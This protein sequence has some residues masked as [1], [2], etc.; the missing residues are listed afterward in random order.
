[1]CHPQHFAEWVTSMHAFGSVDPVMLA[2][3]EL[4][5]AEQG[6]A[7]GDACHDCHSPSLKRQRDWLASL[8]PEADPVLEDVSLDGISCDVCHSIDLIP[9]AGDISFL[10]DVDPSGPKLGGIADPVANDFHESKL[11]HSFRTSVQC[12]SCHQIHLEN[13]TGVEN[14]FQEWSDSIFSGMGRE[15]QDCHMPAYTGPAATGGPPDRTVHHHTFVGVDFATVPYRGIDRDRQI[16]AV[17][18]LLRNSVTVMPELPLVTDPGAS[19]TLRFPVI[20]DRTGHSI[21]S[22]TTFSREMWI[23]LTVRDA[24]DS[25]VYR[26]GWLEGADSTLVGEDVDPDL[27]SFGG[28]LLDAQGDRTFFLWRAEAIDESRLLPAGE[29][30]AAEYAFVVPLDAV[31]PLRVDVALRFRAFQPEQLI[32][33]GLTDL[34]PVRIFDM[35]KP[36][37]PYQIGFTGDP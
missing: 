11:D 3:A 30:R 13:G 37:A 29:T 8:P 10:A 19:V 33:L 34:L 14:T 4:A 2:S 1:V 18:S 12:R 21:P 9:P 17:D 23:Q 22:G 5:R 16:A 36:L 28:R 15:C 35:W 7:A 25:L 27:V 20:N 31:S 6:Q 26:S 24:R 32:E